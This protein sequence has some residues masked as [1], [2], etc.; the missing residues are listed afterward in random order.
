MQNT[1]IIIYRNT[2]IEN[3]NFVDD[4]VWTVGTNWS[5]AD[6]KATHT[7]GVGSQ[8]YQTDVLNLGVTYRI[9]IE[10]LDYVAG[11]VAVR[12]GAAYSA[13][14]TADGIYQFDVV[15]TNPGYADFL[16]EAN[17]TFDGSV[18]GISVVES[19][20]NFSIELNDNIDVPLTFSIADIKS[21]DKRNTTYS[22]TASVPGT[23]IN[24]KIFGEIF[25]I[26]GDGTYNVNKKAMA[27]ILQDGLQIFNGIVQLTQIIRK[28]DGVSDYDLI[29]YQ[30]N[31][32]G[33]LADI[34]YE[35]GDS[36]LSD[37]DFSEYTHT[38]N[39]TNQSNTWQYG[40][41]QK[42]G[43][44]YNNFTAGSTKTF[45]SISP[46]GSGTQTRV[47]LNFS[48]P[49]GFVITDQ[50]WLS[51]SGVG[52][53]LSSNTKLAGYH[54]IYSIPST[55][56][57]VLNYGWNS[58]NTFT[59]SGVAQTYVPT[60]E[61][62]A[63][64]MIDYF[65]AVAA[66]VWTV[67]T[68]YPAIYVKEYIDKMFALA[69]YTYDCDFFDSVFFKRLIVPFNA[70]RT[71]LD[72]S[73]VALKECRAQGLTPQ[74]G[75]ITQA[76]YTGAVAGALV[77][78]HYGV[79]TGEIVQVIDD[80]STSGAYDPGNI[81]NVTTH[82][83]T[84]PLTGNYTL[85]ASAKLQMDKLT[86]TGTYVNIPL[87]TEPNIKC[88][89]T[90]R[91]LTTSTDIMPKVCVPITGTSI[92]WVHTPFTSFFTTGDVIECRFKFIKAPSNWRAPFSGATGPVFSSNIDYQWEITDKVFQVDY[93]DTT[94]TE[95]NILDPSVTVPANI[96]CKD[97]F[98]D[99]IKMF[100]LYIEVDEDNDRKLY[101]NPRNDFYDQTPIDWTLKLDPTRDI[102]ISP[103]GELQA[104]TY[105]FTYKEDKDYFNE[106]HKKD[107]N[108]VYGTELIEVD[109]DFINGKSE[110]KLTTVSATPLAGP[111]QFY[112]GTLDRTLSAI[113]QADLNT[114]ANPK[115]MNS[116]V[117]I[118]YYAPRGTE[119]SW[120]H[121][122]NTTGDTAQT[123]YPYAG[124]L[125]NIFGP[126]YDLDFGYPG[127]VY[128][129][130]TTWTDN[131][132]YNAYY[133][134]FIDEITN[135]NSKIVTCWL[136]L[137]PYDIFK[138]NFRRLYVID[139]HFLRLN[140]ISDYNIN[141]DGLTKCEF[142]KAETA[143]RFVPQ[144][145]IGVR[146]GTE[147]V[148]LL[149]GYGN[150]TLMSTN[151]KPEK[152]DVSVRGTSNFVG[153]DVRKVEVSGDNNT[154]QGDNENVS[155]ID[156][157]NNQVDAGIDN[158]VIINTDNVHATKSGYA[159]INGLMISP[160][161]GLV[162]TNINTVD[163][164]YNQILNPFNV[165]TN[166]NFIDAGK[167]VV[168]GTGSPTIINIIDAGSD[169]VLGG[170]NF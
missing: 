110:M 50:I 153:N 37:L 125:D 122:S 104:K 23:K 69:N 55:T 62:Y 150:A 27:I 60:G 144:S 108:E 154:V 21:P 34:F 130:Y 129:D 10:V 170:L 53:F 100:N 52:S 165:A 2:I 71:N 98:M 43:S 12:C 63:Y 44:N 13:F 87:T 8:I 39:K 117:R 113:Y 94:I 33:R 139:N 24:N 35:L 76:Y 90:V 25:E 56:E 1:E 20:G 84:I 15:S 91:N 75:I 99:I 105:L 103:M 16:I 168:L 137:K 112:A 116:N 49:H 148:T 107:Y 72:P 9:T 32:I 61:G 149:P 120:A 22:K 83:V 80:D 135:K 18:K 17:S 59:G 89:L 111:G 118:L 28:Q 96:L 73:V 145:Y 101:I 11:N 45:T 14:M 95:G 78:T 142:I 92:L 151:L 124:H 97:F 133:K 48:A 74:T 143:P 127:E 68:M 123:L 41:I 109:N 166:I 67:E 160:E 85:N 5:I 79:D 147:I 7:P 162:N 36:K 57:I 86:D 29:T 54:T 121:R 136:R 158:I 40:I 6:N 4:S 70:E 38:Y 47:Q 115:R 42:N 106:Q 30:L 164:G 138:L 88:I 81:F 64:P 82:R 163:A 114:G 159:W 126:V 131:N 119:L 140:K 58:L 102:E 3:G 26:S 155:I 19:P 156:G 141:S 132:L 66:N 152:F 46:L 93:I 128:Y 146:P 65:A 161:G 169:E 134:D 51:S 31:F 77:S 167:D 157:D